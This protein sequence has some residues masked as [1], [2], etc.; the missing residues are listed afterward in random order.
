MKRFLLMFGMLVGIWLMVLM[1][2]SCHSKKDVQSRA[3]AVDPTQPVGAGPKKPD[4]EEVYLS[5]VTVYEARGMMAHGT[6]ECIDGLCVAVAAKIRNDG[7]R[8]L[9]GV[10][11]TASFPDETGRTVYEHDYW[12][13]SNDTDALKP[14][15]IRK[16]GYVVPECPSE[17]VAS[18]VTVKVA[19]VRFAT[20]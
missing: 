15:F 3:A 16:F 1:T 9:K 14:G 18:K 4:D 10:K 5:K 20:D 12:V 11:V 13:V 8:T 2:A 6:I 17:C 7:D 19:W